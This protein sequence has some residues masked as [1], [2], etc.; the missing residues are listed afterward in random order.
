M[1]PMRPPKAK[2]SACV[3]VLAVGLCLGGSMPALAN[4]SAYR[5]KLTDIAIPKGAALG[6]VR[7]TMQP[8]PNWTLICDENLKT[9]TKICNV[10]QNFVDSAGAV[11]FSWSLAA[12][13]DGS[14][15]FVLRAPASLG[16]KGSIAVRPTAG[17]PLSALVQACDAT[18]CIATL[19]LAP[20]LKDDIA[21]A[22]PVTI[23][24]AAE[25]PVTL[26]APLNGLARALA[27]ID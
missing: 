25:R 3:F 9:Q 21:R 12:T 15:V 23:F 8:F 18:T 27:A 19:A 16:R 17:K 5:V 4:E 20:S 22:E 11:V 7:R 2:P 26:S 24:Y 10:T 13:E 14:P 6:E 1:R